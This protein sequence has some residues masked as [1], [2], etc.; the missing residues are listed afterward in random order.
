MDERRL[1]IFMFYLESALAY[2]PETGL[3]PEF[4]WF[5]GEWFPALPLAARTALLDR[6][7][8]WWN[9]RQDV[10]IAGATGQKL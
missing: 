8:T 9:A 3:R 7:R 2:D 6:V 5:V 4:D 10:T 1:H